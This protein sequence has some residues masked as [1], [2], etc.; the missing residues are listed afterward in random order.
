MWAK[1]ASDVRGCC[2]AAVGQP[3]LAA[4]AFRGGS[5]LDPKRILW[6]QSRDFCHHYREAA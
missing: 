2:D 3:I 4:A 5:G 6:L 1:F